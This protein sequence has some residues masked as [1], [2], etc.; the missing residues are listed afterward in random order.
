MKTITLDVPTFGFI[1]VTRALLAFGVGLLVAERVPP[2]RRRITGAV[3][4]AIGAIATIPALRAA[5]RSLREEPTPAHAASGA[6]A[7]YSEHLVGAGRYPRK[8]DDDVI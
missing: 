3:L 7:S 4:A 5:R 2:E 1:V 6:D 8:G